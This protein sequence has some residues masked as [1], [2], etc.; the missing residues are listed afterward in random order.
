VRP[1]DPARWGELTA[2]GLPLVR[3][4]GFTEIAPGETVVVEGHH[5]VG[6]LPRLRHQ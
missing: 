4:A 1:A 5:R 3:D 6:S 2:S